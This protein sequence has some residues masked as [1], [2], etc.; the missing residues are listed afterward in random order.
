MGKFWKIVDK[1][2]KESDVLLLLLDARLVEE[3]MNPEVEDKVENAEKPLI[4][5]ITKCD[6]V[7]KDIVEAYKKKLKPC[8]FISAK[9]HFGTKILRDRILTEAGKAG[10][11][12][13]KTISVGVLGYPNVGKSSLINAMKGKKSAPTSILSGYTKN[14]QMIRTH[15]R[16][17]LMDTP[18]VIP[19]SENDF[20]KHA[21]IGTIDF[22]QI[23]EAD[24]VALKLMELY[25]G[26]VEYFYGVD[27]QKDKEETIK[28]IALKRGILKKGGKP[29]IT[30]TAKTILRD[31]QT[32]KIK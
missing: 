24:I 17:M 2:I 32:G 18:G 13:Y 12:E 16:I 5:V 30:K 31:W 15:R 21:L 8:V 9:K 6:L 14:V 26:M 25:P 20:I 28:E 27:P 4:Y 19:Y 29:D 1:V 11:K 7:D 10:I 3:T 23:R 22:N